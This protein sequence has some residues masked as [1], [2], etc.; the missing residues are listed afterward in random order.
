MRGGAK[1]LQAALVPFLANQRLDTTTTF[2]NRRE[3]VTINLIEF[4]YLDCGKIATAMSVLKR[5]RVFFSRNLWHRCT[6]YTN[7][8]LW[9]ILVGLSVSDILESSTS[10]SKISAKRRRFAR[11]LMKGKV[12]QYFFACVTFQISIWSD[13]I[14]VVFPRLSHCIVA[15]QIALKIVENW[16][17]I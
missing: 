5:F 6:V 7:E 14:P 4:I 8:I 10:V 12:Q 1:E 17:I 9:R 15:W 3:N 2:W 11:G 13:D 16:L